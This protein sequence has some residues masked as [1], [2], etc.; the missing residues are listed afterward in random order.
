VRVTAGLL[1]HPNGYP[2]RRPFGSS[3]GPRAM[4]AR[5]AGHRCRMPE[6]LFDARAELEVAGRTYR[7]GGILPL[8]PRQLA[9]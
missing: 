5:A 3:C 7:L 6:S 2:A 4:R 1:A 9:P 8:V